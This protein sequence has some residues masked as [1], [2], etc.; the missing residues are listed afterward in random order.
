MRVEDFD[1]G[2]DLLTSPNLGAGAGAGRATALAKATQR[3]T[4]PSEKR[5]LNRESVERVVE[6]RSWK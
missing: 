4:D 5:M 2:T 3:R 1:A 6:V